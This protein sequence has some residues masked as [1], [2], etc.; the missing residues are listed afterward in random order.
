[1]FIGDIFIQFEVFFTY[2]NIFRWTSFFCVAV[3]MKSWTKSEHSRMNWLAS[4][5]QSSHLPKNA[6]RESWT[7]FGVV[8]KL[9]VSGMI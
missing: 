5:T 2:K 3:E 4:K 1:M 7:F 8:F 6:R 9:V